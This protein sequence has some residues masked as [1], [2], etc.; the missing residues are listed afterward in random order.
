MNRSSRIVLL[1]LAIL[2]LFV[3]MYDYEFGHLG[4]DALQS[5]WC[6]LCSSFHSTELGHNVAVFLLFVGILSL[7]GFVFYTSSLSVSSIE[8]TQFSPRAPPTR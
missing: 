3:I 5:E 6:P 4:E 8:A 1:L 2:A 7:L